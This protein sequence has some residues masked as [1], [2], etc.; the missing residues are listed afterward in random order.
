MVY[1]LPTFYI[2]RVSVTM[3]SVNT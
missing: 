1:L 3:T 2:D